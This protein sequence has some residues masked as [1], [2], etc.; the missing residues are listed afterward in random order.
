MANAHTADDL[1]QM[2]SLS[3]GSKI[4]MT[5]QRIR[6]WYYHWNGDV[7]LSFSGG[8]D[9]TVLKHIIDG[10]T[11]SGSIGGCKRCL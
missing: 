7:Y 2:Q 9:S 1:R 11:K 6:Q 3:L 5:Q 8:K 10:M 4:I